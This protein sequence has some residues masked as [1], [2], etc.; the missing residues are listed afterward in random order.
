M[1]LFLDDSY[2]RTEDRYLHVLGGF[3]VSEAGHRILV[4]AVQRIKRERFVQERNL[5][6]EEREAVWQ[7]RFIVG[8]DPREVE[9]KASLLLSSSI[10]KRRS[11]IALRI[12]TEVLDALQMAKAS[13]H[14]A[15]T[16]PKSLPSGLTP[17][18]L[19]A[20][21]SA[22]RSYREPL[23]LVLD[24]SNPNADR[25]LARRFTEL[26]LSPEGEERYPTLSPT[27]FILDTHTSPGLQVADLVAHVLLHRNRPESAR[28]PLSD[29]DALLAKMEA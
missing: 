29:L 18:L 3:A 22:Q 2:E 20:L 16:T 6:P 14:Y 19:N 11:S 1:L 7:D 9:L 28:K 12:A 17:A 24:G 15:V 8:A 4:A 25:A 10:L 26:M 23:Q 13:V 27:P 5:S 21:D